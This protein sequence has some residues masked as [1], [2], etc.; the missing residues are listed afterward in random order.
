MWKFLAGMGAGTILAI[1]YVIFNV[2]LPEFLQIP[3]LVRGGVISTTTEAQLYDL[4]D[5]S[6]ARV[7]AL[8]VY[9]DNRARDA[10][11]IDADA[12]HPFL[13]AL[14]RARATREA[15][16][17]S[18][19]WDAFDEALAQPSLRQAL[20]RKH[21]QSDDSALKQA[22]LWEALDAYPFLKQWLATVYGPQ[23]PPTL[24][25]TLL[26]ARRL[27]STATTP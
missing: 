9:F 17:L 4:E 16:L 20:E 25:A 15:R 26:E 3:G 27:P 8:E 11:A 10:A 23:S 2:Q 1:V 18:A 6:E 19:R 5:G 22:M 12:G 13:A 24:Y 21:G 7:R 14:H